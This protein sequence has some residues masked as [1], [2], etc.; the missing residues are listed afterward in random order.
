MSKLSRSD[1]IKE[2]IDS[3]TSQSPEVV[4]Y[5]VKQLDEELDRIKLTLWGFSTEQLA[6][7][8]TNWRTRNNYSILEEYFAMKGDRWLRELHR[9]E[10]RQR[11][12][13]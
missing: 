3:Y 6:D 5:V 9:R 11:D 4:E 1:I 2:L 8:K 13:V 10:V 7:S 12:L